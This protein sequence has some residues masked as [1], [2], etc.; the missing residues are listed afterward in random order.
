MGSF[1]VDFG[2]HMRS[3]II[4]GLGII[5]GWGSF[6]VLYRTLLIDYT[7]FNLIGPI[8]PQH[9]S[10]QRNEK[11]PKCMHTADCWHMSSFFKRALAR[12]QA[13][14][15]AQTPERPGE[16]ARRL[17]KLK[18]WQKLL[19][20]GTGNLDCWR[21]QPKPVCC[22]AWWLCTIKIPQLIVTAGVNQTWIGSDQLL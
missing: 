7:I 2:D 12:E 15:G 13:L 19:A 11:I 18:N 1:A 3:R 21:T 9:T 5:Y 20:S 8:T 22:E 17:K 16:L 10:K 4:C 14:L 6:A